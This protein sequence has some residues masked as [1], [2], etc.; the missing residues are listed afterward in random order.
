MPRGSLPDLPGL[1][2]LP[3]TTRIEAAYDAVAEAYAEKFGDELA[4]K[5]FDRALLDVF[6]ELVGGEGKVADLG[7][8]PG[9]IGGYLA[10]LGVDVEGVDV[11]PGMIAVARKRQPE[12]T[13][14]V[15]RFEKLPFEDGS[16]GG[17]VAAYS[18][19]HLRVD[20]L[21]A[22]FGEMRRCLAPGAPCLVSFHVG[23]ETTR[24]DELL[25]QQV[26]LD[27]RLLPL[28]GVRNA[29]H[30]AGFTIEA[31]LERRGHAGVEYP[32]QRAY[33]LA[34]REGGAA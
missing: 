21:G 14:H 7:C 12:I 32:S 30:A 25:G 4:Q 3:D 5:P 8:G 9:H 16:L 1:P 10:Q 13:F 18:I 19:V 20:Q 33:V 26:G 34:R 28:E 29:L 27:F 2:A 23:D 15:A 24:V 22:I 17:V 31:T 6:A 11:S